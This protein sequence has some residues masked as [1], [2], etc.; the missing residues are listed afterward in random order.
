MKKRKKRKK[1]QKK[2]PSR[3]PRKQV[4]RRGISKKK[5]G[6]D[7]TEESPKRRRPGTEQTLK[8]GSSVEGTEPFYSLSDGKKKGRHLNQRHPDNENLPA[9]KKETTNLS[10]G[11]RR[12]ARRKH[13][14]GRN[15][16]MQT[17]K[18]R[19]ITTRR[20]ETRFCNAPNKKSHKP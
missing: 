9:Q 20:E 5:N 8:A 19:K 3:I 1:L 12:K 7:D 15:P 2:V 13:G 16:V 17:I 4:N 18:K 6:S 11:L 10:Y 14:R